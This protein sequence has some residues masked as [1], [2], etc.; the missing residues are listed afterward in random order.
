MYTQE[1]KCEECS[2]N[3]ICYYKSGR[4]ICKKCLE[5]LLVWIDLN[6]KES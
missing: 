2:K 4:M 6:N 5:E 1:T 3:T